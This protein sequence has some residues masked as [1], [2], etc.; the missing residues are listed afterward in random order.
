MNSIPAIKTERGG[1]S[2]EERTRRLVESHLPLVLSE[3]DRIYIAPGLGLERDD[4]ISAGALGLLRAAQR[5]DPARGTTFGLFARPYVRGAMIDE[6]RRMLRGNP[7][8]PDT[9]FP[10]PLEPAD[11][12]PIA[13]GGD[14]MGDPMLRAQ[15]K[16]LIAERLS[17]DE[18]LGL[19]LYYYEDLTLREIAE[20]LD[21]SISSAARLVSRAVAKL[22][23]AL[24]EEG[25]IS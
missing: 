11:S 7:A 23:K 5:F 1:E 25:G 21:Q 19:A 6:I 15:V 20:V 16:R 9:V 2:E 4:L 18:R 8:P 17:D 14:A 12:E 3:M 10:Q 22:R 13:T 24:S